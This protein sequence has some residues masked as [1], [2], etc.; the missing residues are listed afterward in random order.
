MHQ[1]F[2]YGSHIHHRHQQIYC[3]LVLK[4]TP[5]KSIDA[6][7]NNQAKII[8]YLQNLAKS[9]EANVHQQKIAEEH[10]MTQDTIQR[11]GAAQT[12]VHR[13]KKTLNRLAKLVF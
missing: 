1:I 9:I 5:P 10:L 3:L 11:I 8:E 12:P 13:E 6:L 4:N 7:Q 2:T